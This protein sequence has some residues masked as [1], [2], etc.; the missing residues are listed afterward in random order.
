MLNGETD[1]A[2]STLGK[3]EDN[4]KVFYLRAVAGARAQRQEV[5]ISNLKSAIAADS[6]LKDYAKKDLEFRAYRDNEAF[7]SIVE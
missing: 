6:S 4:A 2:L 5:V 3:V 7:T 1:A